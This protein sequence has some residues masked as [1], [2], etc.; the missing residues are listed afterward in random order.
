ME[1]MAQKKPNTSETS[2]SIMKTQFDDIKKKHP[3]SVL[4]FRVGDFY[5]S[6]FQD[7]EKVGKIC[8][9]K[10][11][12]REVDKKV[13]KTAGFPSHA[14]DKYLPE[15]VRAGT[16]V[17]ICEQLAPLHISKEKKTEHDTLT[18][19]KMPKTKKED[20]VTEQVSIQAKDKKSEQAPEKA[21]ESKQ[22][23]P[24]QMVTAN[25]DKV[26]HGHAFQSTINKDDWYFTAKI[27]GEQLKPQKM[28]PADLEAY[29]K[30][31]MTVP[32]L[33]EKYY[34]TKLMPKVP[35]KDFKL[36]NTIMGPEGE[37]MTVHRFNV[38]K[39]TD[40]ENAHFG[41]YKFYTQVDDKKMSVVPSKHDLNAY[42]DRVM[43]PAQLVERNFGERLHLKSAYEH[44]KLPEGVNPQGIQI[45]KNREDNKWYV[46][47]N[48]GEKGITS[49]KAISF[50]DGYSLFKAKTATRENIAAKY[51]N[52]EITAMLSNPIK[53]EKS[54]SL[55]M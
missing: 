17:A 12:D 22:T 34:P 11:F 13:I 28:A 39:E 47:V 25:G 21:Q 42:Y 55:K 49:Q 5:E 54:Q 1:N 2:L 20:T 50:D 9:L 15:L 7:A 46:S 6:L 27:N 18:E 29:K 40:V 48:L 8:D 23:R 31:E 51:L 19:S 41:K 16:R 14:L 45:A 53:Q 3:D 26:T 36:P 43:T 10:V 44:H 4:L 52:P 24:P 38:Y 35:E 30:K 32:Q 33:M 37:K